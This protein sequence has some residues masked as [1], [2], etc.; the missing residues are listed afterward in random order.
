LQVFVLAAVLYVMACTPAMTGHDYPRADPFAMALPWLWPL[1]V[2]ASAWFDNAPLVRWPALAVYSLWASLAISATLG[3]PG[4]PGYLVPFASPHGWDIPLLA[5]AAAVAFVEVLSQYAMSWVRA[6]GGD[7][8]RNGT[9]GWRALWLPFA[10]IVA[11]LLTAGL[12]GCLAHRNRVLAASRASGGSSAGR[13]WAD[14]RPIL[15]VTANQYYELEEGGWDVARG[16]W[17]WNRLTRDVVYEHYYAGHNGA[18][19]AMLRTHGPPPV[20]ACLFTCAEMRNLFAEGRLAVP[21]T[22]PFVQGRTTVHAAGRVVTA[23]G[24]SWTAGPPAFIHIAVVP[25]KGGV[26]VVATDRGVYTL[27]PAGARLQSLSYD[28][29]LL[30]GSDLEACEYGLRAVALGQ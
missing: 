11:V 14:G 21:D 20:R 22:F 29:L 28:R 26:A 25:E 6:F 27:S 7:A 19:E 18:I 17:L 3:R 9:G 24:T 4:G 12:L 16:L 8:R 23:T 30:S 1:P 5:N 13:T 10:A 15:Y 2:V